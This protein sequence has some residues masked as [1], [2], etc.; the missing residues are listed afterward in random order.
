MFDRHEPNIVIPAPALVTLSHG[1]TRAMVLPELPVCRCAPVEDQTPAAEWPIYCRWCCLYHN[2]LRARA[3]AMV[4]F[5]RSLGDEAVAEEM[6]ACGGGAPPSAAGE[7]EAVSEEEMRALE[8]LA[9]L[10]CVLLVW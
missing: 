2:S 3:R 8:R 6:G 1:I 9:L 10:G 5:V 7:E 4:L